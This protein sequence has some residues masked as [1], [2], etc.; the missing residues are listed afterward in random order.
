MKQRL[1]KACLELKALKLYFLAYRD[2]GIFYEN[3][4]K[5]AKWLESDDRVEF[6]H[7][8]LGAL[9]KRVQ[10]RAQAATSQT[11]QD[12]PT[13]GGHRGRQLLGQVQPALRLGAAVD[14]PLHVLSHD[15]GVVLVASQRRLP[16]RVRAEGQPGVRDGRGAEGVLAA[17]S[18]RALA[19]STMTVTVSF[20]RIGGRSTGHP[21]ATVLE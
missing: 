14:P 21:G 20:P 13:E 9:V 6:G 5:V 12:G 3:A 16:A 17:A 8:H 10:R 18:V 19:P 4:V 1:D 11:L 15:D 2:L 7:Y